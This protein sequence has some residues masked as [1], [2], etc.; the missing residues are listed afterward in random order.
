MW[1]FTLL[2]RKH[3]IPSHPT[4]SVDILNRSSSDI[5]YS[6]TSR[7]LSPFCSCLIIYTV[8]SAIQYAKEKRT[9]ESKTY[10]A[11]QMQIWSLLPGFCT[12]PTDLKESFKGIA[13]ILGSALSDRT[14]LK[15]DVLASLRKLIAHSLLNGWLTSWKPLIQWQC[16]ARAQ[17]STPSYLVLSK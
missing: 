7:T 16:Y 13:K 6:V 5:V 15:M 17:L 3:P 10:D 2:R 14:D 12:T 9:V 11:L 4:K 8:I 1:I